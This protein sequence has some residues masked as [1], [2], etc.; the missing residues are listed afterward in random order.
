MVKNVTLFLMKICHYSSTVLPTLV[1]NVN[2]FTEMDS[3]G[4]EWAGSHCV[5]RECYETNNLSLLPNRSR[6]QWVI[7]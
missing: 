5:M 1:S 2:F 7:L 4:D 3:D 6:T